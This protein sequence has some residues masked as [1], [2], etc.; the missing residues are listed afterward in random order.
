MDVREDPGRGRGGGRLILRADRLRSCALVVAAIGLAGVIGWR[1]AGTDEV[2]ER[3]GTVM[4]MRDG[5]GKMLGEAVADIGSPVSVAI[6]LPVLAVLAWFRRG[7]RALALVLVGPPLAMVT[8]STILK[9]IIG[10]TSAS[11]LAYPSGHTTAAASLAVA[12]GVLVYSSS[13]SASRRR[14]L[15]T[16]LG[17]VVAAVATCL[18]GRGYHYP[19]DTVGGVAVALAAVL[20]SAMVIDLMADDLADDGAE[21]G[22]WTG[23][24]RRLG[25]RVPEGH[26]SGPVSTGRQP[27]LPVDDTETRPITPIHASARPGD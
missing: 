25:P 16:G 22:S 12:A 6:L 24:F 8:T 20:M 18:V 5:L 2:T 17:V 7:P 27:A 9:P 26:P 15:M 3:I 10:R 23:R 11:E 13:L 21:T 1:V 4:G 14:W 19:T